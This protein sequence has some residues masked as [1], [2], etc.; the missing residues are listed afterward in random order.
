MRL[1]PNRSG[2]TSKM[3]IDGARPQAGVCPLASDD[4]TSQDLRQET[5]DLVLHQET[6]G[7]AGSR[8]CARRLPIWQCV[9]RLPIWPL[10]GDIRCDIVC[11]RRHPIWPGPRRQET[12]DLAACQETS[13]LALCWLET[14]G[15][16][17]PMPGDI[18]FGD[19]CVCAAMTLLSGDFRFGT[20]LPGDIRFDTG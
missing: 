12:S 13:D 3:W 5:S 1:K 4:I 8:I 16:T 7:L 2:A 9:R 6:S 18:R 20:L 15:V 11:T 19:G 10:P 17:S 14:S